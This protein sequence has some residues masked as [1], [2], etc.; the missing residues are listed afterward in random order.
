MQGGAPRPQDIESTRGGGPRRGLPA[1]ACDRSYTAH[2]RARDDLRTNGCRHAAGGAWHP[3][4]S[5]AA[6]PLSAA[7]G[8]HDEAMALRQVP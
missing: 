3:L 2:H 8:S 4:R 6:N 5:R 1:C 7:I